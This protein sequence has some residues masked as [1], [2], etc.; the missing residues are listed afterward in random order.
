MYI[1]IYEKFLLHF[2]EL[3]KDPGIIIWPT[4]LT[5]Y[6]YFPLIPTVTCRADTQ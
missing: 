3:I 1:Y 5:P 4:F 6:E 2:E